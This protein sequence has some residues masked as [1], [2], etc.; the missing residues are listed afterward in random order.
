MIIYICVCSVNIRILYYVLF[1]QCFLK[2]VDNI[3]P[4][5][6]TYKYVFLHGFAKY[7]NMDKTVRSLLRNHRNHKIVTQFFSTSSL[8]S[9]FQ[10]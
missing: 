6:Y 1:S 10:T 2:V 3:V 4:H 8:Y 5:I 9:L 7:T